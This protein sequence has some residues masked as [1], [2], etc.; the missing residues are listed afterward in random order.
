MIDDQV[1]GL[2]RD[3]D[4]GRRR[5][6]IRHEV[7][8]PAIVFDRKNNAVA[9]TIE[10][11]SSTGMALKIDLKTPEPGREA[12]EQGTGGRLEFSV[13]LATEGS[14]KV[15]VPVQIMWRTPIGLGVRFK[16][17][18]DALRLALKSIAQA[19]V[20]ARGAEP[21]PGRRVR[22]TQ[23]RKI[24]LACRKTAEKLLPNI[25]WTLRTE[26]GRRLRHEADGAPVAHAREARAEADLIDEKAIP[27]GRTIERQFLQ[28]FAVVSDLDQTQELTVAPLFIK[29]PEGGAA[30]GLDVVGDESVEQDSTIIAIGHA[31]AEKFKLKLFQLNVRLANVLGH[32]L[33]PASNPLHPATACRIFWQA[34]VEY[35]DSPRVRRCLYDAIRLRVV[36]LIGE[37]YDAIDKTLD[38]EG[39]PRAFDRID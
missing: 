21:G 37:L 10:D 14:H 1:E 23:H 6:S 27:I 29:K 4:W 13:R 7:S 25:I 18:D 19:A 11:I 34:T 15:Q 12:L 33:D 8:L 38:E 36:P 30:G 32:P 20:E 26:V 17:S 2:T 3:D 31:A 35:V 9:C 22:A 5:G 39:A 24:M 16:R 28:A